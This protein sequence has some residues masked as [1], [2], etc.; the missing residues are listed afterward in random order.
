MKGEEVS[1]ALGIIIK[2]DY[3]S[4]LNDTGKCDMHVMCVC[5]RRMSVYLI[6]TAMILQT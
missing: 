5:C 2:L 3:T 4:V 1:H 6:F